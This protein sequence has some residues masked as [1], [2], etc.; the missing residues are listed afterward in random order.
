MGSMNC[1]TATVD[2]L[3]TIFLAIG[4]VTDVLLTNM[5]I[6][7]TS[8]CIIPSILNQIESINFQKASSRMLEI[9]Y[10]I[11]DMPIYMHGVN[12]KVYNDIYI[13]LIVH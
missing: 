1:P 8:S 12:T 3:L 5:H 11:Y 9:A 7:N 10:M 2:W 13:V 4:V 6:S